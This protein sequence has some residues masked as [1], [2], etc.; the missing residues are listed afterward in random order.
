MASM[1]AQIDQVRQESAG[2]VE[3]LRKYVAGLEERIVSG[4]EERRQA[5]EDLAA[6]VTRLHAQT[7]QQFSQ[8]GNR[9]E[10]LEVTTGQQQDEI[11][12]QVGRVGQLETELR[13][14]VDPLATQVRG[15]TSTW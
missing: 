15:I 2:A 7:D 14:Q 12:K 1:I 4:M 8:I 13:T 10:P 6:T 11:Q 3:N 9:L 5:H